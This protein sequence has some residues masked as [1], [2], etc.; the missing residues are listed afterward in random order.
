MRFSLM[1]TVCL[2]VL[3]AT[4]SARAESSA[5]F[6]L[7][8]LDEGLESGSLLEAALDSEAGVELELEVDLDAEAEFEAEEEAEVDE[9]ALVELDAEAEAE[10]E[11]DADAD[12]EAD[13]EAEAEEE[14]EVDTEAG[15]EVEADAENETEIINNIERMTCLGGFEVRDKPDAKP[16]SFNGCG[17]AMSATM[18][19]LGH[20][21]FDDSVQKCCNDHDIG[22]DTCGKS[23]IET[24]D[25]F[26]ACLQKVTNK[27]VSWAL[28]EAV[29]QG[30]NGP[31]TSAQIAR[32]GC[33][34]KYDPTLPPSLIRAKYTSGSTAPMVS[35]SNKPG[36]GAVDFIPGKSAQL[37][38]P[39]NVSKAASIAA[40]KTKVKPPSTKK[41]NTTTPAKA[42]TAKPASKF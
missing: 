26:Y 18:Q 21:M 32:C 5:D 2:A 3:A 15:A 38:K 7:V 36:A 19:R 12:A 37:K 10:A 42:S 11:A 6:S 1:L 41:T 23:K 34:S 4:Y 35:S 8:E 13:A 29:S 9:E 40:G 28:Y 27:V 16:P 31:F 30:G 22:Y 20:M 24:D 14:A 39:T 17:P 25:T 33:Y